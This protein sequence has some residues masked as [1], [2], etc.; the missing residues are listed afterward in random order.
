MDL[1]IEEK[2]LARLAKGPAPFAVLHASIP[3]G[4]RELDRALQRMRKRGEVVLLKRERRVRPFAEWSLPRAS[5]G[6]A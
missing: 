5:A 4:F 1:T 3:H 2:I 6:S